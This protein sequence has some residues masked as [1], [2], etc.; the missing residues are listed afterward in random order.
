VGPPQPVPLVGYLLVVLGQLVLSVLCLL[1]E[2]ERL[3]L[4]VLLVPLPS[5]VLEL[6]L[7][8]P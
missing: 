4:L 3:A 7:D 1:V 6:Q 8:L 5:A 2:Q